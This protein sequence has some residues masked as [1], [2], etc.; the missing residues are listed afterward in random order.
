VRSSLAG[1]LPKWVLVAAIAETLLAAFGA[2]DD[3][4]ALRSTGAF[5]PAGVAAIQLMSVVLVRYGPLPPRS[6]AP[7][8]IRTGVCI[9]VVAGGL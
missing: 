3:R 8:T 4:A 7:E 9:G 6:A 5:A 1:V 2:L